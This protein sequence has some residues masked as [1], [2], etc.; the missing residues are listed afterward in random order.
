MILQRLQAIFKE[1]LSFFWNIQKV[2]NSFFELS[3]VSGQLSI[4]YI[5][6]HMRFSVG[7]KTAYFVFA[8][9]HSHFTF[10][11]SYY[12]PTRSSSNTAMHELKNKKFFEILL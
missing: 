1:R 5:I 8:N 3:D 7:A 2:S 10:M 6:C 11:Y 4:F 9:K 12:L